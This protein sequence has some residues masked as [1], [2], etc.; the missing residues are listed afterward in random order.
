MADTVRA[1]NDAG[2]AEVSVDIE[3]LGPRLDPSS[4]TAY[5]VARA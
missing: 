1:I 5:G 4:L 3:V 2:F